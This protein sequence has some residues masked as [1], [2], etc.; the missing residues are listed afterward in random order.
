M[1]LLLSHLHGCITCGLRLALLIS[2]RS[3]SSTN[4][5]K[6][7]YTRH[8]IHAV[9]FHNRIRLVV[10]WTDKERKEMDW[11]RRIW[12]YTGA[13]GA[14]Q[15]FAAG[16][17]LWDLVASIVHLKVLGGGSLAHAVSALLVTS[18]GFVSYSLLPYAYDSTSACVNK[19]G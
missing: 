19:V 8:V 7:G 17:F 13:E 16:Y 12:R 15:G 5:D 1:D 2:L 10:I 3:A 4:D 18:L 14:V 11:V 9:L 6:L